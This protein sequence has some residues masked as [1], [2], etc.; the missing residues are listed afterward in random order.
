MDNHQHPS[1]DLSSLR[2]QTATLLTAAITAAL[3]KEVRLGDALTQIN[4]AVLHGIRQPGHIDLVRREATYRLARAAGLN[5]PG[6][7][8]PNLAEPLASRD[9]AWPRPIR[10]TTLLAVTAQLPT[11][12]A[13]DASSA[14][15]AYNTPAVSTAQLAASF[16]TAARHAAAYLRTPAPVASPR[17]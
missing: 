3:A 2:T 13:P 17:R 12:P 15:P 9:H 1:A 7:L 10:R 5:P 16:H 14:M 4:E 11:T 6:L 8:T